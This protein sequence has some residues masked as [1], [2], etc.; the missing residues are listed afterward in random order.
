MISGNMRVLARASTTASSVNFNSSNMNGCT[1]F[2]IQY[3]YYAGGS[4]TG[5]QNMQV[6]LNADASNYKQ[7]IHIFDYDAQSGVVGA[8][9]T[10]LWWNVD[11]SSS[12]Y[13]FGGTGKPIASDGAS[14][15]LW[16]KSNMRD[17][18]YAMMYDR[19]VC[20]TDNNDLAA[21]SSTIAWSGSSGC[22]EITSILFTPSS[23]VIVMNAVLWGGAD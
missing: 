9:S 18:S 13:L 21:N 7:G 1:I 23:G 5:D 22:N 14:G 17:S 16:V 6:T 3:T 10:N 15:E 12:S 11:E 8:S 19:N 4:I 20:W 2:C